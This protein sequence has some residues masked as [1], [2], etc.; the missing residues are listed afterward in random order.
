[1][2]YRVLTNDCDAG[3]VSSADRVWR[4]ILR[5]LTFGL[6]LIAP[7]FLSC[8]N[9]WLTPKPRA[10]AIVED[11]LRR[12]PEFP[13]DAWRATGLDLSA[14]ERVLGILSECAGWPNAHFLPDDSFLFLVRSTDVDWCAEQIMCRIEDQC[15]YCRHVD[16]IVQRALDEDWT[17]KRFIEGILNRAAGAGAGRG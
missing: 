1:M 5:L 9:S 14:V 17:L 13:H 8:L 16:D 12:R 10:Y 11:E 6:D 7:A 15:T 4:R 2:V 3:E